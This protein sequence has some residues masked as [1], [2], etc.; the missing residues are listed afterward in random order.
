MIRLFLLAFRQQLASQTRKPIEFVSSLIAI[1]LNNSFYLY[2]IYLLAIVSV[3][4]DPA[5][6][7]I[8]LASTGSVLVAW[9]LLN[10]FGGG[11]LE[12]ASLIETGRLETML[13]K[14]RPALL[15]TAISKSNLI[16]L[17][18]VIQGL[19]TIVLLAVLYEPTFACRALISA[20]MLS[21]AFTAV[22]ISIGSLSFFLDF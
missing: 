1:T 2:G 20:M 22:V 18:E 17:G 13:A 19:A 8:Y 4:E 15:L 21:V 5:A 16:S 9:G 14:P 10:M 12:L 11:L 6:A 7:K 3:G